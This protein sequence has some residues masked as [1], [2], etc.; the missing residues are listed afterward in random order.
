VGSLTTTVSDLARDW[1]PNDDGHYGWPQLRAI[2][3]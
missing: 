3:A 2:S 1:V